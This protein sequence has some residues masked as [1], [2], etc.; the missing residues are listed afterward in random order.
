M[1]GAI[2]ARGRVLTTFGNIGVLQADGGAETIYTETVSGGPVHAYLDFVIPTLELSAIHQA[3]AEVFGY[4]FVYINGSPGTNTGLFYRAT[5]DGTTPTSPQEIK[6]PGGFTTFTQYDFSCTTSC[7]NVDPLIGFLDLGVLNNGD[8]LS[9]DYVL[10]A[11]ANA[12]SDDPNAQL[13]PSPNASA[14]FGDP[15]CVATNL[16]DCNVGSASLRFVPVSGPSIPE[17]MTL[18]LM[19]LGLVGLGFSRRRRV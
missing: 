11:R 7:K 14:V 19:G 6:N 15:S 17:P 1:N 8:I 4:A 10:N 12:G 18:T 5:L 3:F 13:I 2:Y 9:V 16:S